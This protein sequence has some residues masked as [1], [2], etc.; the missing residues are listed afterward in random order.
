VLIPGQRKRKSKGTELTSMTLDL[1][2]PLSSSNAIV[3]VGL[4]NARVQQMDEDV[5]SS[6]GSMIETLKKQK[7][8]TTNQ[9]AKSA[10]AAS[11]SPRRAQ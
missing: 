8:G 3:P 5:D 4:V 1:N 10:G 11:S 7:R 6:G 2:I 9:K